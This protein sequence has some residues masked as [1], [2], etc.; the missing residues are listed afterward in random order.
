MLQEATQRSDGYI[1]STA[2]AMLRIFIMLGPVKIL[3]HFYRMT[4]TMEPRAVRDGGQSP[5]DRCGHAVL[6]G[7]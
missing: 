7:W 4:K 1:P 5:H 6:G 3:A 2:N